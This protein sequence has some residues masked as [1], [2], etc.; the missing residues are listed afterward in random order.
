MRALS[1]NIFYKHKNEVQIIN[2]DDNSINI[3]DKN[4]IDDIIFTDIFGTIVLENIDEII[5]SIAIVNTNANFIIIHILTN[6]NENRYYPLE[7]TDKIISINIEEIKIKSISIALYG[8]EKISCRYLIACKA[9]DFPP[10]SKKKTHTIQ[11]TH[12][13]YFS[14]SGHYF[15]RHLPL[16]KYDTW[17]INFD[18]L[19]NKDKN[20]ILNFFDINNYSPFILQV[21]IENIVNY[22]KDNPLV[23]DEGIYKL[24]VAAIKNQI[25]RK[26]EMT[27]G[28]YV[29]TNE[30]LDF[31]KS[32]NDIY[33][34]STSLTFR[35][36]F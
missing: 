35:E 24:N 29:C 31:K 25:T 10:H 33:Q 21:W 3:F 8:S 22:F 20:N 2:G 4:N 32:N 28:L 15:A 14:Q 1:E 13:G 18:L 11:N 30:K 7:I 5:N 34:W 23:I 27:T 6:E 26:Y 16:K 17:I 9:I 19:T 36:V 12:M